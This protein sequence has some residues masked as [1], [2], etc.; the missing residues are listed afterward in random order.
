MQINYATPCIIGHICAQLVDSATEKLGTDLGNWVC[1]AA[2]H[3]LSP[4]NPSLSYSMP[5]TVVPIYTAQSCGKYMY[6]YALS[7]Y[8]NLLPGCLHWADSS[9]WAQNGAKG[10]RGTVLP[11][12]FGSS[13]FQWSISPKELAIYQ[14]CPLVLHISRPL[15]CSLPSKTFIPSNKR[16]Q[17]SKLCNYEKH[18]I[19][20][21]T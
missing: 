20:K 2:A 13:S 17:T 10:S 6:W 14:T 18:E 4:S 1:A 5:T 8:T 21:I 15:S 19:R 9:I 7:C 16:L 11:T 3:A 12:Y